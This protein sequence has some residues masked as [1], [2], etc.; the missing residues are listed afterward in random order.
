MT[1]FQPYLIKPTSA[2]FLD[3]D[4]VINVLK[5]MD[6]VKETEEF[7]LMPGIE[8][9]LKI[10]KSY[11]KRIFVVTNQQGVGKGLMIDSVDTIHAYFLSLIPESLHPDK[12]YHCPHLKEEN[13]VCR[14]PNPGMA[15]MA[16][17]DFPEIDLVHSIIVGDSE[18]DMEFGLNAGM[19]TAFISSQ[20]HTKYQTFLNLPA[21]AQNLTSI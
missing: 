2:L 9:S 1:N 18:S 5:H 7:I 17:N 15:L 14:K 20:S 13:C 16:K 4:G 6:Y 11:F 19:Q 3:R 8:D 12:L 10:F 21:F